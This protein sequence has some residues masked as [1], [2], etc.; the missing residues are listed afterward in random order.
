MHV[1][2]GF[3]NA[4]MSVATGVAAAGVVA[5]ALSRSRGELGG[6]GPARA[7]LVACF[8]FAAQLVNFPVGAGTSGHLIGGALAAILVG[9][10]TAVLVLTSVLLVQALFFADGGLTALGTNVLLLAVVAVAVGWWVSRALLKALPRRRT[11]PWAAG[12]AGF[13]SVPAAALAF[14]ALYAVGGAV[15]V[16]LPTLT[17]AMVG[18]HAVIGVGEGLI[19]AGVVAAVAASQP[20][21]IHAL[22]RRA[23][24]LQTIGPDGSVRVVAAE[25]DRDGAPSPVSPT[26]RTTMV[27]LLVTAAVASGLSLVASTRPDGLESVAGFLGF[28]MAGL[29][30]AFAG[31]PL[32]DYAIPALGPV[33]TSLAGVAGA[34]LT[35]ALVSG[36]TAMLGRQR[37][38][39]AQRAD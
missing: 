20:Q 31:S 1:P 17:W 3:L 24:T 22:P 32:A 7:G 8:V 11:L 14:T 2:D 27:A 21:L 10:W 36:L 12:L 25:I 5:V 15:P 26:R 29:E 6:A 33:G 4:P 19:T 30:S 35:L 16:P 39:T 23:R 37:W 28:D 34:A 9:P 18:V 38:L 13:V